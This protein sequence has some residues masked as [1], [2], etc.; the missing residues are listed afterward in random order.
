[1][2]GKMKLGSR[3][4]IANLFI[5]NSSLS[6]G[7]GLTGLTSASASLAA[8][9]LRDGDAAPTAIA[10]SAG[11][12]GTWSSGGFKEVSSASM[13]GYYQLGIPDAALAQGA[14]ASPP[15]WV[16]IY[17]SGAANMAQ[18]ILQ[19]RLVAV[20]E[21]DGA[22]FGLSD[23]TDLLAD[24][25][26]ILSKISGVAARTALIPDSP[27]AV[28]SQMTIDMTQSVPAGSADGS[29]GK[30]LL[31]MDEASKTGDEMALTDAA[32]NALAS[33]VWSEKTA[34]H[35][36]SGS[37]GEALTAQPQIA[38]DS[39]AIASKVWS[40]DARTLTGFG[41]LVPDIW[42]F[43]LSSVKIASGSIGKYIADRLEQS[44][45]AGAGSSNPAP[46]L[47]GISDSGI[48]LQTAKM[49]LQMYLQH[50]MNIMQTGQ[51]YSVDTGGNRRTLTRA[52]LAAT[53]AARKQWE[54]KVKDLSGKSR[55]VGYAG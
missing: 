14:L 20:D 32:K 29:I 42:A 17:L 47:G 54:Q 35:Q 48:S 34:D 19:I 46:I 21:Q 1:M 26:S 9:Y 5:A 31:L 37:T 3:G 13:P 36:A 4:R 12:T 49:M 2:S 52:D 53:V 24:L 16:V 41:S 7:A 51:S 22:G 43:A 10:L 25:D 39:D 6:T 11:T 33:A 27:A 45:G 40:S 8:Y 18:T 38:I 50:E 15:Q 30:S 23:F 55:R 28:G 44:A